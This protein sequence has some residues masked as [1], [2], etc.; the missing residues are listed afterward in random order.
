MQVMRV[1]RTW[2][3]KFPNGKLPLRI[4]LRVLKDIALIN[5]SLTKIRKEA[6]REQT[7]IYGE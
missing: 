7:M 4:T 1:A 3:E 5:S 2:M 6:G